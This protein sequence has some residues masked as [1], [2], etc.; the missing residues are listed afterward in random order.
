[1]AKLSEL[2]K[3]HKEAG[4]EGPMRVK[5]PYHKYYTDFYFV[6]DESRLIGRTELG[7][8]RTMTPYFTE[9]GDDWQLYI[10]PK[11]KEDSEDLCYA[12]FDK[13][14]V[15]LPDRRERI[16]TAALQGLCHSFNVNCTHDWAQSMRHKVVK[17]SL[18]I[19]DALIAA[20]DKESE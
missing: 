4:H 17:Q 2:W 7:R 15:V 10:E 20:L 14:K 16:A 6:D 8:L 18:A 3:Q 9:H 5:K 13:N 1:M 11:P 19:A 12:L